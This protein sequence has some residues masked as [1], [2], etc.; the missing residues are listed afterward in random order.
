MNILAIETSCDETALSLIT[1][2]ETTSGVAFKIQH[3]I[4]RTQIEIHKAYGGVFPALGKREH[5]KNLV[6]M[7]LHIL[8]NPAASEL[9]TK[10][11]EILKSILAKESQLLEQI[12]EQV[13][14]LPRPTIDRIC[15]TNGPGLEPALWV[16]INFAQALGYLWDIPVVPIN[17]MEGHILSVLV[18]TSESF[19]Y[20]NNIHFPALALLIS[21]GHTE[22]VIIKKIGDYEIIGKTRDDA[23]GEAFDKVARIL[24]I[25]YPGGPG[26]SSLAAYARLNNTPR[27]VRL[28]RPMIHSTDYDFSFSGIKTAV[29]YATND[30]KNH[31][32]II[33]VSGLSNEI[34]QD[35]AREFE[36]AVT[37]V[38]IKK[39]SAAIEEFGI[40][41]LIIG[42]GVSANTYITSEFKKKLSHAFPEVTLMLPT[43]EL[44]GDNS[45]MIALAGYFKIQ[46]TPDAVYTNIKAQGTL[47]L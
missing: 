2:S 21:G 16:G 44:T 6:P 33:E 27:N 14:N 38:L 1:A 25:P 41:T 15:V 19:E 47:G 12:L 11:V 29:L 34:K 23:V 30:P 20:T 46:K 8:D 32:K 36:E 45:L 5:Q 39:T 35:I 24:G 31:P 17:H 4:T 28:P 22:L 9:F 13:I 26:V 7:L 3:N 40:Q 42:G 10:D 37:E 43:Q 18:P